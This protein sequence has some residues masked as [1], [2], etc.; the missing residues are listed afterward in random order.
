M[1]NLVEIAHSHWK[2]ST[3]PWSEKAR[4]LMS[5]H[6]LVYLKADL[7]F[8]KETSNFQVARTVQL[9]MEANICCKTLK[10]AVQGG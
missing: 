3:A 6:I 10:A 5:E 2:T 7:S 8:F 1:N 4:P 9:W